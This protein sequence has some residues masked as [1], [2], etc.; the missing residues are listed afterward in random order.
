[1]QEEESFSNAYQ[2]LTYSKCVK[3]PTDTCDEVSE[4][5]RFPEGDNERKALNKFFD[6]ER[7]MCFVD[8]IP[9]NKGA[10]REYIIDV[11]RSYATFML[12]HRSRPYIHDEDTG[13]VMYGIS[14]LFFRTFDA[15]VS[16][17]GY[18]IERCR[19]CWMPEVM[20]TTRNSFALSCLCVRE[21]NQLPCKTNVLEVLR[22]CFYCTRFVAKNTDQLLSHYKFFHP[23]CR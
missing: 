16:R 5:I 11:L 14:Q 10:M 8:N 17:K 15:R 9:G 3:T 19:H 18:S 12:A 4:V 22:H 20:H 21:K 1:M 13:S 7:V 23:D 6:L 2:A